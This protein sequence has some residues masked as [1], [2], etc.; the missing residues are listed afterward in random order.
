MHLVAGQRALKSF[1]LP[2]A[3]VLLAAVVVIQTQPSSLP[4][5]AVDFYYYAAFVGGI[6]IAWRFHAGRI[7]CALAAVA[8]AHRAMEFFSEGHIA[9][10]G[11]GLVAFQAMAVLLPIN[12]ILLS[13]ARERGLVLPAVMKPLTVLF[14]ESVWVAVICR[15]GVVSGPWLL[16]L[17]VTNPLMTAWT[18]LPQL[19]LLLYGTA[20]VYFGVRYFLDHKPVESGLFWSLAATLLGMHAGGVGKLGSAYFATAGVILA[21]S[22]IEN[23]Y[24]LAYHDELT[25]LPSRRAFQ[26]A[27]LH[28]EPPYAIAVVDIDHFKAFNDNYGHDAGDQVLRMVA[29]RLAQVSGGGEAYRVG[30]E[31]FNILFPDKSMRQAAVHLESLRETISTSTFRV[32]G[33][34]ERR[35][36]ARGPD[37][38]TADTK[39]R[40]RTID[41]RQR[42]LQFPDHELSVTVSIGVAEPTARMKESEK[43]IEA[44]DQALYRAKHAGRNR[45]ETASLPRRR[46]ARL[47]RTTA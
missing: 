7:F 27:M 32:R 45:V 10:S 6:L 4:L 44:A 21:S 29:S 17:A 18:R 22:I 25:G 31:E 30:G 13:V 41:S 1:L 3:A 36:D 19:S 39:K 34:T 24:V 8:L 43:V 37:R 5:A 47:R 12:F 35:K 40:R 9:R 28:L 11:P 23:S 46:T 16:R 38:R 33:L 20:L 2:G 42:K 26:E 15:P 14:V